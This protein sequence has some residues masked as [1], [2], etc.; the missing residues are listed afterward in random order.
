MQAPAKSGS[1]YFNYKKTHSIV[2][3]ATCNANYEFT[4]VDIGNTGR[5]S[6][7]GVLANS[8]IDD[9]VCGRE[10]TVPKPDVIPGTD[11]KFRYVVVGG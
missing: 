3:L 5:I 8:C 10:N 4:L 11:M 6:D 2:L 1:E 9:V 7:G